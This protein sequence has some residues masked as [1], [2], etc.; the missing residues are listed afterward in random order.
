MN[1]DDVEPLYQ[2]GFGKRPR[3]ELYDLGKDPDYMN[4]VATDPQYEPVRARMEARLMAVILEEPE[5]HSK[6]LMEQ[7]MP[8]I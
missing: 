3:E 6:R 2:L 4:N 1:R 8:F 7:P 5:A